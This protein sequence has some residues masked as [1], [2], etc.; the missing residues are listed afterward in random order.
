M[1]DFPG[2]ISELVFRGS[3]QGNIGEFSLDSQMLKVLMQL[4]GKRNMSAVTP[5]CG[6]S[7]GEVRAVLTRLKKLNLIEQVEVATPTLDDAFFDYLRNQYSIALGPI[8]EV[9][10]DDE[11][12]DLGGEQNQIP[13]HRS[14]E[15]V[16][17]L[18]RQ[19]PRDE[20]RVAFQQ[21][22]VQRIREG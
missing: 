12:E 8:A 17:N 4:D 5:A 1:D 2:D 6:L 11:I 10:I 21:A 3:V 9:L 14:A 19:I 22:M 13:K 15:L 16:N 20:K 7:L 18:A